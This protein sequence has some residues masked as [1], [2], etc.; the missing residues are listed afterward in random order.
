MTR[1][2][3][4]YGTHT[5]REFKTS[6]N[7]Q[8]T[9]GN[10]MAIGI[11]EV[12]LTV[13]SPDGQSREAVLYNVLHRPS[14]FTNLVSARRLRKKGWYLHGGTETINRISDNFQLASALFQNGLYVLPKLYKTPFAA[15]ALKDTSLKTW[16]RRLGHPSWANLK[17]FANARGIDMAKLREVDQ[18]LHMFKIGVLAKQKRKPSY[19]VQSQPE[20]ICKILHVDLMGPISPTRWNGCRYAL[21]FADGYSRC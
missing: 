1:D 12:R 15:V 4:V 11:G 14:L 3:D 5:Y 7:F 19:K 9:G 21:T 20:D 17:R 6:K 8:G 16:Y 13:K 18:R 2:R 10:L